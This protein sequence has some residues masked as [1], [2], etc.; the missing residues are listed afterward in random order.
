MEQ[1]RTLAS[2]WAHFANARRANAVP[3]QPW[4]DACRFFL[5]ESGDPFDL[6]G[7]MHRLAR[8][9]IVR[10]LEGKSVSLEY[11]Q[12]GEL[13]IT[14]LDGIVEVDDAASTAGSLDP[15]H[16][17]AQLIIRSGN[18]FPFR[19]CAFDKCKKVFA[20]TGRQEYCVGCKEKHQVWLR[21]T[22]E[23]HKERQRKRARAWRAKKRRSR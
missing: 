18:R 1:D 17:L 13:S 8:R 15:E 19:V 16:H 21:S 7:R 22:D 11:K 10:A 23:R 5:D 9:V 4:M 12:M 6:L 3:E 14:V 2:I 20:R